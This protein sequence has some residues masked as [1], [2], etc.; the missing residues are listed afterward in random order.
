MAFTSSDL[1]SIEAAI[2]SLGTGEAVVMVTFSNGHSVR[3]RETDLG[4]LLSLRSMIQR[5]TGAVHRR[6]YAG[7]GGRCKG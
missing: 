4:K 6:V 1:A 5:E 7:N 2:L 3:Y